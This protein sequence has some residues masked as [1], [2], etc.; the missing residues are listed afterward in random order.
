M[1]RGDAC[2]MCR[3]TNPLTQRPS[4]RSGELTCHERTT[5]PS[6]RSCPTSIPKRC[7]RWSWCSG[8]QWQA[9]AREANGQ[10]RFKG[11]PPVP[12][13]ALGFQAE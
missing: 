9:T 2:G 10:E 11:P 13:Q 3:W 6:C 4:R 1:T 5:W 8:P 12:F 7:G